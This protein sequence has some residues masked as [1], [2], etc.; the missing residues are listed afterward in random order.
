MLSQGDY[1]QTGNDQLI[2]C[3]TDGAVRGYPAAGHEIQGNL[4]DTNIEQETLRE[5]N[6]KKQVRGLNQKKQVRELNQ[7]K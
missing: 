6:Q 1:R 3:S 4:M 7:K 2:C 5:L